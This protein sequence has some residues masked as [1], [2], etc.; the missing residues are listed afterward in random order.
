MDIASIIGIVGG[1]AMLVWA[2][3]MGSSL[4]SFWDVPSILITYGGTVAAMFVQFPLEAILDIPRILRK[5]FVV[6]KQDAA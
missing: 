6:K 2:M 5:V 1:G 4:T 3:S